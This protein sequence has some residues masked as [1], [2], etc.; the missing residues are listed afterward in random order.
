MVVISSSISLPTFVGMAMGSKVVKQR[1]LV[2]NKK[3]Y[4]F[5]Q[6][7]MLKLGYWKV[8]LLTQ[9]KFNFVFFTNKNNV[10]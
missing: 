10:F 3:T 4:F 7:L 2:G 8:F 9:N 6:N 1:N 5:K